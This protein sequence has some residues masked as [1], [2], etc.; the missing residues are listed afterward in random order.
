MQFMKINPYFCAVTATLGIAISIS[1]L[2]GC[3]QPKTPDKTP[4]GGARAGE[5]KGADTKNSSKN[6]SIESTPVRVAEAKRDQVRRLIPVTG[7]IAAAH[8]VEVTPQISARI[9]YMIGR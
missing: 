8:S 1:L 9:S 7:S 3:T 4:E 2:A 5:N 6:A